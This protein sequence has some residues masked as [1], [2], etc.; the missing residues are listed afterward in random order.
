MKAEL[1]DLGRKLKAAENLKLNK[2]LTAFAVCLAIATVFWFLNSLTRNYNSEIEF[3]VSYK[4]F[5]KDKLP[6]NKLPETIKLVINAQGFHL[7]SY[8]MEFEKD[9][10]F[11]DLENIKIQQKEKYF[12]GYLSMASKAQLLG[13]GS[14]FNTDIK[15]LRIIPDTIFFDFGIKKT[16][17]VPVNLNSMIS[18]EKQ[19][20]LKDKI[21]YSP[22]SVRIEGLETIINSIQNLETETLVLEQ[23]NQTI[24]KQIS[25]KLPEKYKDLKLSANEISVTIPIEKYTEKTIEIPI[26]IINL[27]KHLSLKIFPDKV[28]V[29]CMVDFNNFDNINEN[30]FEAKVDYKK[31]S[32]NRIPIE[33]TKYP[34]FAKISKINPTKVEYIVQKK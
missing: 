6:I 31:S 5:P 21:S 10:I 34:D 3:P 9:T 14:Q 24:T 18:F 30:L 17:S 33:I 20:R 23:L 7:L 22:L 11:V 32:N 2:R 8:K 27:P 4:N 15:V 28:S 1:I 29:N 16:K 12:D 13:I 25:I 26:E 19:F